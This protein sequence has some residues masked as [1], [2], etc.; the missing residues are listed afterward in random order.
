MDDCSLKYRWVTTYD[1]TALVKRT[2]PYTFAVSPAIDHSQQSTGTR[3]SVKEV[4]AILFI[5]III[6]GGSVVCI[7]FKWRS[8]LLLC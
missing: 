5:D 7:P 6:N 2:G 4:L 3:V 8:C 1:K